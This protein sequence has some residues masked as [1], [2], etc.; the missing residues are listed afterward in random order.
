MSWFLPTF[1]EQE[2]KTENLR[3]QKKGLARWWE[4]ISHNYGVL[5]IANLALVGCS[6]P[7]ALC[8]FL[9]SWFKMLIFWPLGMLCLTILGPAWAAVNLIVMQTI[10]EVSIFPWYTFKKAYMENFRQGVFAIEIIGFLWSMIIATFYM[11]VNYQAKSNVL[12]LLCM[13]ISSFLLSSMSPYLF[14]Q[15]VLLDQ[16]FRTQI[17][18]SMLLIFVCGWRSLAIGLLQLIIIIAAIIYADIVI[19][20]LIL[21]APVIICITTNLFLWPKFKEIFIDRTEREEDYLAK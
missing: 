3:L 6:I 11:F 8:F 19:W 7:A 13:I 4:V 20:I 17:R 9:L 10:R 16:P 21:G 5:F 1:H 18:N 15:I 12:F 14:M 2:Y